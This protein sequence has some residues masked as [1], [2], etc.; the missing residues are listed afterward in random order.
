[1][2]SKPG[3]LCSYCSEVILSPNHLLGCAHLGRMSWRL[4]SVERV[5]NS[6]C[7]LC[8][9]VFLSLQRHHQAA[10]KQIPPEKLPVSDTDEVQLYWLAEEGPFQHGAFAVTT[11]QPQNFICFTADSERPRPSLMLHRNEWASIAYLQP[12][13]KPEFN[14]ERLQT[15]IGRCDEYHRV[16]ENWSCWSTRQ[17]LDLRLSGLNMLRLIDV[18]RDC[19]IECDRDM[20]DAVVP[21]YIAL[22]YVWG[23]APTVRLTRVNKSTLLQPRSLLNEWNSLPRTI[24]DAIVLV[25]KLGVE[26]LWVDSLCLVQDDDEDIKQGVDAMDK[27]YSKAWLT[28]IAAHGIDADAGLPGIS[29]ISRVLDSSTVRVTEEASVGL[30]E[31]LDFSMDRTVYSTR[32]W[33]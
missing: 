10:R 6:A 14:I 18:R 33:T 22:S 29:S 8:R 30:F 23:G 21:Q 1:M 2:A 19:I 9:I 11:L 20:Q 13:I 12:D 28:I 31:D 27:I 5:K 17:S 15:W 32:A 4:G 16:E 24:H 26:Y 3:L 25:R 7:P